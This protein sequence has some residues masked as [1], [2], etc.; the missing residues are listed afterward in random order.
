ME[1]HKENT[2]TSLDRKL[3]IFAIILGSILAILV[4]SIN[5][6]F[7]YQ[8]EISLAGQ[9]NDYIE[10]SFIGPLTLSL[11]NVDNSQADSLI[12]GM[13]AIKSVD[14][15]ELYDHGKL[16]LSEHSESYKSNPLTIKTIPLMYKTPGHE[17]NLG[18]LIIY[19]NANYIFNKTIHL[20]LKNF[21]VQLMTVFITS[22]VL[23]FLFRKLVTQYLQ[24]ISLYFK[25]Y[26]IVNSNNPLLDLKKWDFQNDEIDILE[27]SINNFINSSQ[28]NQLQI[29]ELKTKAEEANKV[30]NI[31]LAN[32]SHELRTPLNSII[33]IIDV[34]G[35]ANKSELKSYLAIQKKAGSQLMNLVNDILD[36]TKIEAQEFKLQR[37]SF[38]V[39]KCI[40]NCIAMLEL[41]F[42]EKRNIINFTPSPDMPP[43]VW[44]DEAR[45][46]QIILNLLTNANKFTN[47]GLIKV[48]AFIDGVNYVILVEDSGIGIS[49]D[50]LKEI[51]E[52]FSQDSSSFWTNKKGFGIGLSVAK[53]ITEALG[54]NIEVESIFGEGSKFSIYL[55]CQIV[56]A[57]EEKN[58]RP[59]EN[60][61]SP[62]HTSSANNDKLKIFIVDDTE[63]NLILL[64]AFLKG[65]G[66]ELY[67]AENGEIAVDKY[68][69]N[70]F[71][72]IFMDIQMPIK[73][74]FE[75]TL[76]IRQY[77]RDNNLHPTPIVALSAYQQKSEIDKAIQ[78]G[79]TEYLFKPIQKKTFIECLSKYHPKPK[80]KQAA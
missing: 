71:D 30:K 54:G 2:F 31:F 19:S 14:K 17:Q 18:E 3:L 57:S 10:R 65:S 60:K 79:C 29:I 39:V 67:F 56:E 66:H 78:A 73:N 61:I 11:W 51:F 21:F 41:T 28:Q 55:P 64:Q 68:K 5:A 13:M 22:F 32:I 76:E 8:Q 40:N 48:S 44:G 50:K 35:D 52:P 36:L 49:K 15:I 24:K 27:K 72:L 45:I 25:Q 62:I 16:R 63:D 75:A 42:K 34:L 7:I 69:S 53:K 74:G 58:L 80:I 33:G 9:E 59:I 46:S 4:T 23:M 20:I 38:S 70:D 12:K 37:E 6:Y 77:E 47:E 43:L 26:P 1:N